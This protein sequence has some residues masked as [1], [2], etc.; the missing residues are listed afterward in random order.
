MDEAGLEVAVGFMI[1]SVMVG[2]ALKVYPDSSATS[3][4]PQHFLLLA[5]Q[6][7]FVLF[8]VALSSQGVILL[9][10]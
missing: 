1:D 5:P 4:G 8:N 2:R 10:P 7:H 9:A 6:H 3:S